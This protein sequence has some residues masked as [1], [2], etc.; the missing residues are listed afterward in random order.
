[1]LRQPPSFQ[2]PGG[3][4]EG[5][6]TEADRVRISFELYLKLDL[7]MRNWEIA[8]I[9]KKSGPWASPGAQWGASRESPLSDSLL[10]LLSESLLLHTGLYQ[11]HLCRS[12]R[13]HGS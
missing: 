11:H 7:A 13:W 3:V 10:S 6:E 8:K 9:A 4:T 12:G 5:V 1:M 2:L